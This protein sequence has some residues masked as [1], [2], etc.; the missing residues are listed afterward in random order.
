MKQLLLLFFIPILSYSQITY[1]DIMSINSVKTFKRV[2]IEGGYE[3]AYEKHGWLNYG[4]N[5]E[6]DYADEYKAT[7][8]CRYEKNTSN[9][10]FLWFDLKQY[11]LNVENI[12]EKCKFYDVHNYYGTD[13]VCYSCSESKYK[14]KIGFVIED[15]DGYIRHFGNL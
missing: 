7:E 13:Y 11:Y 12:K 15:G 1:E 6:K 5:L 3:F 14:G 2:V 4:K 10:R 8:W 9:F